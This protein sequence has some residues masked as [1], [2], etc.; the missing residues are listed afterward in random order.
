MRAKCVSLRYEEG[1]FY[2]SQR[3][4]KET[5]TTYKNGYVHSPR[6]SGWGDN[7]KPS[8]LVLYLEVEGKFGYS[9][10]D[11]Y[12]KDTVGRL[13]EKRRAKIQAA[14]P[15]T[16]DVEQYEKQD[17]ST[18]YVVSDGDLEAWTIQAGL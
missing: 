15:V 13:T 12:F 5:K 10:I 11:R 18:Y 8:H 4:K 16:V 6:G 9:W 14:M 7:Y 17:G 1:D 2:L 3:V